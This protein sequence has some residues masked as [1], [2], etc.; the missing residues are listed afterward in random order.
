MPLAGRCQ[1][2]AEAITPLLVMIYIGSDEDVIKRMSQS[3]TAQTT[4]P[5]DGLLFRIFSA[6]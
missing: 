6:A 5:D 4:Y 1:E 2:F 3:G